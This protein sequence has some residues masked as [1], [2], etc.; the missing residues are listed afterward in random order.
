DAAHAVERGIVR[1][2]GVPQLIEPGVVED[3]RPGAA[4][5]LDGEVDR[6]PRAAARELEHAARS[7]GKAQERRRG[8]VDR[9]VARRSASWIRALAHEGRRLRDNGVDLADG[10]P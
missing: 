1:G 8:I 7:G 6:P 2:R 10:G 4:I 9:H 5:Y 3:E